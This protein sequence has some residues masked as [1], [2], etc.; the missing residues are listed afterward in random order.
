[1]EA[2]N[3]I[4]ALI[5]SKLQD[6]SNIKPEAHREV[7][8]ALLNYI[9]QKGNSRKLI[10]QA[11]KIPATGLFSIQIEEPITGMPMM[12]YEFKNGDVT[13]MG[14]LYSRIQNTS[15]Q[16]K[17]GKVFVELS[18]MRFDLHNFRLYI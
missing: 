3:T 16:V 12:V 7:L 10:F 18:D 5:D 13:F 15:V 14:D 2:N 9:E 1:M 4:L 8:Y 17:Q 11:D 6:Y